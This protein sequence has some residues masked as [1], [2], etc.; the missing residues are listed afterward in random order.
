MFMF[1]RASRK[2]LLLALLAASLTSLGMLCA[3]RAARAVTPGD[4][5]AGNIIDDVIFY[6]NFAMTADQIQQFLNAKMPSC[7]NWGTEPH[8]GTT[9][10]A[11]SE[12]RGITF[13][14]TC[15]KDYYENPV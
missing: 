2:L 11:Y 13:P 10:R 3:P 5:R 9:R 7:D 15:L 8:A 12:A 4:W 1:R 6:N 14:L